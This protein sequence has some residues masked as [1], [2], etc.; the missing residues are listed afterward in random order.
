MTAAAEPSFFDLP[1]EE[2]SAAYEAA[3]TRYGVDSF[4]DLDPEDRAAVYDKA[5]NDSWAV[6]R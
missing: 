1:A 4:W 5:L 2:R 3:E 6:T